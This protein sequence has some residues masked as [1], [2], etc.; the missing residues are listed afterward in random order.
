MTAKLS[1]LGQFSASLSPVI[2]CQPASPKLKSVRYLKFLC[3]LLTK[4]VSILSRTN[5]GCNRGGYKENTSE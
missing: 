3:P 2:F 5:E 4:M 1:T